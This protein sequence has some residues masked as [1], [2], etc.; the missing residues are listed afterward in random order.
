M[1]FDTMN[2]NPNLGQ[3][4]SKLQQT[5]RPP[6]GELLQSGAGSTANLPISETKNSSNGEVKTTFDI[7]LQN[8]LFR[9]LLN[10][11]LGESS[12]G[13]EGSVSEVDMMDAESTGSKE[14]LNWSSFSIPSTSNLSPAVLEKKWTQFIHRFDQLRKESNLERDVSTWFDLCGDLSGINDTKRDCNSWTICM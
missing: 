8:G 6:G 5:S 3:S 12:L 11:V 7:D 1:N 4:V 2:L 10:Q 14:G 13:L 9:D